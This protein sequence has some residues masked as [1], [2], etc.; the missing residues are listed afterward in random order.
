M[1][2]LLIFLSGLLATSAL[3]AQDLT[4]EDIISRY[5]K[6]I[7]QDKFMK[8]ETFKM[9]GKMATQGLE[10]QA[11]M[12]M[13]KPD[14]IR[15]DLEVQG[16]TIIASLSGEK[17]WILNP[18]T[19]SQEAQEINAETIKELN[20]EDRYDPSASWD[21][22][23][24]TLKEDNTRTELTGKFDF[25]GS[26]AYV[27]KLTFKE[28]EV[29]DYYIDAA[30]FFLVKTKSIKNVQGQT[31]D[32]EVISGDYKDFEGIEIPC[33]IISYMNGQ[34]VQTVSIDTCE[35]NVSVDDSIF[36]KPVPGA[37]N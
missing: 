30:S 33:K 18:L 10:M 7:G 34:V 27:L 11:V 15:Q 5:L 21:N 17:G 20:Q 16:M 6:A 35:L 23:F 12:Y 3:F 37:K 25:N 36:N 13:K 14:K 31:F 28:G 1:K 29:V 24:L 22:P 8:L 19:G 4:A 26:P 9:K 2:K 32:Q